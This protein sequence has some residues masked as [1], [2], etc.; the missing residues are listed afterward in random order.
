MTNDSLIDASSITAKKDNLPTY[1][2]WRPTYH[3][4]EGAFS[5][6]FSLFFFSQNFQNLYRSILLMHK[7]ILDY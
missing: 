2:F 4:L 3:S 7:S 1:P 5:W 6:L